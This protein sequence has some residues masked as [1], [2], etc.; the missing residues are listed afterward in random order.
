MRPFMLLIV[1]LVVANSNTANGQEKKA[2]AEPDQIVNI[3]SVGK[4]EIYSEGDVKVTVERDN[5]V[6]AMVVVT[7][8]G[9][10]K[11][12]VD[13]TV[14]N[15]KQTLHRY[16]EHARLDIGDDVEYN[17]STG[18]IDGMKAVVP[19]SFEYDG[20]KHSRLKVRVR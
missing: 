7:I 8:T 13:V 14:T 10:G 4:I 12:K 9:K 5:G 11:V 15:L 16:L 17:K 20:E 18:R 2:K 19:M 6:E 1:L 3:K